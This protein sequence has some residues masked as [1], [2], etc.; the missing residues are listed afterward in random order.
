MINLHS[1]TK[2]TTQIPRSQTYDVWNQPQ[3]SLFDSYNPGYDK[4]ADFLA[5]LR[6]NI[7]ILDIAI[8]KKIQLIGKYRIDAFGNKAVQDKLDTFNDSVKVNYFGNG[9]NDHIKQLCD[10]TFEFGTSFGEIVPL[11]DFNGIYKLKN[12]RTK[13]VTFIH[14]EGDL[15]YAPKTKYGEKP[16]PFENQEFIYSVAFDKRE[17]RPDGMSMFNSLPFIGQLFM[18]ILKTIENQVWRMGDPTFVFAIES[19]ENYNEAKSSI[20]GLQSNTQTAMKER[21]VGKTSDIFTALPKG[22]KLFMKALGEGLDLPPLEIPM[23]TIL[24]QIIAKTNFPPFF[25]GIHWASTYNITKHQNDMIISSIESH[26]DQLNP[27]LKRIFDMFLIMEGHA[28]VPYKWVWEPVNLLDLSE[29]AKARHLNTTADGKQI[30]NLVNLVLNGWETVD[31]AMETLVQNNI[32]SKKQLST[33]G[34]EQIFL[35]LQKQYEFRLAS[36]VLKINKK[37]FN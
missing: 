2:L 28:G 3:T 22:S 32:I 19:A 5:Y 6:N 33:E 35:R 17:G 37:E 9:L 30:D 31:G 23:K 13:D 29:Q 27:I 8:T 11:A 16:K 25:F 10:S 1:G 21:R 36:E 15:V 24:E 4:N 14:N 26:R 20:T 34:K 18:R 7:P 12:A